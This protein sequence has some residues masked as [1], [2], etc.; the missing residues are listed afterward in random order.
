MGGREE[1]VPYNKRAPSFTLGAITQRVTW[2]MNWL[3]LRRDL[4]YELAVLRVVAGENR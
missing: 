1:H 3:L 2:I 4:Y